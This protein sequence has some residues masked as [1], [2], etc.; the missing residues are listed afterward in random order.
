M[1]YTYL[2]EE[3][4]N[5]LKAVASEID[6]D[7]TELETYEYVPASGPFSYYGPEPSYENYDEDEYYAKQLEK[8]AEYIQA[9]GYWEYIDLFNVTDNEAKMEL[10]NKECVDYLESLSAYYW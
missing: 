5:K 1:T 10:L 9:D 3:I 7:I 6:I 8:L 2:T 4:K